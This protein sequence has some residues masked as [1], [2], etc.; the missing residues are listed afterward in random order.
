MHHELARMVQYLKVENTILRFKVP[1]QV[2]VTAEEIARLIRPAVGDKIKEGSVSACD[3]PFARE[4]RAYLFT[5]S[6]ERKEADIA[7]DRRDIA[8]V[9]SRFSQF[10]AEM[11]GKRR[12]E[13]VNNYDH[14]SRET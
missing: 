12:S 7:D 6:D 13:A 9:V 8:W 11:P 3:F 14:A 5:V 10:H 1:K 4:D 2:K